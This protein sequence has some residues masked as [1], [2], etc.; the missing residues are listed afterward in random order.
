MSGLPHTGERLRQFRTRMSD[1]ADKRLLDSISGPSDLSELSD[2]ELA[3]IAQ[4]VR[5][6]VIDVIGEIGGH[7][8]ANLGTCELATVLHS[9]LDS[10]TDKILWD[11]GHQA[12]PHKVLTGRARAAGDDP[13]VRRPGAVLLGVR[14]RARHHGRRARLDLDRLRGGAQGG[15]APRDRRGREGRRRDRRRR[16]HRRG[17]VRGPAQRRRP[18]DA[19]R[20]RAQRQRDVDLA[21]RRRDRPLVPAASRQPAPLPR[22]R[23]RRGGA[24]QAPSRPRPPDREARPRDQGRGQGICGARGCSSRSSTSPTWARSTATTSPRC[25]KR[26]RPRSRPTARRSSTST[27]SRARVSSPPRRAASRGWRSGTRRSRARSSKG[28]RRQRSPPPSRRSRA[29]R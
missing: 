19:D 8:G 26:S 2:E 17:R 27:P 10:P 20:D 23:G 3:Q 9:L 13:P 25:G 5:E 7:F 16:A 24:D 22:T 29:A 14:V 12:Y 1:D 21:E 28:S 18:A 6:L 11:V 15:D 4:E